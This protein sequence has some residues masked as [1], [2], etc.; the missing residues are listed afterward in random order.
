MVLVFR[1][2]S[3]ADDINNGSGLGLRGSVDCPEEEVEMW[4]VWV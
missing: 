2:G 1:P 3:F 4:Q